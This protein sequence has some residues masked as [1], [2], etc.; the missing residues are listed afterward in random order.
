MTAASIDSIAH[1]TCSRLTLWGNWPRDILEEL[2]ALLLATREQILHSESI[3]WLAR[4]KCSFKDSRTIQNPIRA[5]RALIITWQRFSTSE[6][7]A[8]TL[9]GESALAD[10]F[11]IGEG[12]GRLKL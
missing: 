1:I 3:R 4:D 2:L 5:H 10:E 9:D 12:G 8:W 7:A 11:A 6:P